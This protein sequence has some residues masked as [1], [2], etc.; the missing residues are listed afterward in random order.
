MLIYFK[1]ANNDIF[2]YVSRQTVMGIDS[3][4]HHLHAHVTYT[5]HTHIDF[6]IQTQRYK[7]I[8][9]Y[10]QCFFKVQLELAMPTFGLAELIKIVFFCN[11]IISNL[12]K[13]TGNLTIWT[14]N[15]QVRKYYKN[16]CKYVYMS[17]DSNSRERERERVFA[18][19]SIFM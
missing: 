12:I 13:R 7:T 1:L 14:C 10:M 11:I 19:Y 9:I 8:H 6:C 15:L 17:I 16:H 5:T 4:K 18:Y 3:H 2:G